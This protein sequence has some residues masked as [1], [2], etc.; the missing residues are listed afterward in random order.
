MVISLVECISRAYLS[1]G[2]TSNDRKD[3]KCKWIN[4][5]IG[6]P[7]GKKLYQLKIWLCSLNS[8][9]VIN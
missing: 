2:K 8:W 1:Y 6:W 9:P 4:F 7:E 5:W 3:G